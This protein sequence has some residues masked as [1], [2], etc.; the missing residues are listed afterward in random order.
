MAQND[1]LVLYT[2]QYDN[3]SAALTDLDAVEQ[4]HKDELIGSYDAA[5]IDQE[6]GKPKIVKR[7][8]RPRI[9]AIPEAFGSGKLPRKELLD[10]A[11]DL[12]ANNAGLIVVGE[13]TIKKALD[14][15]ITGAAKVVKRSVDASTD[16]IASEL[17][18]ALKS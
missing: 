14:K 15:A 5:V 17:Q 2:A 4:L 13:P 3:V 9:R 6:N 12:T 16:E 8:D 7:M 18:E 11:G 10:A 1:N